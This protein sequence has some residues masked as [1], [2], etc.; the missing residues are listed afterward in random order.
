MSSL[1][2]A[3]LLQ[4]AAPVPAIDWLLLAMLLLGGLALFLFGLE[5]MSQS[6]RSAAGDRLKDVL[7]RLTEHRFSGLM[8]G[9]LVTALTQSSSV[10]TVML[11]GFVGAGLMKL[12]QTVAVIMGSNVGT[13]MTAQIIAFKVSHYAL[14]LVAIGYLSSLVIRRREPKLWFSALAGLGLIFYGMELMSTA[15]QPL[16]SHAPFIELMLSL[17]H[18][19]AG[20]A[21]G[22]L[23]TALVQSS[24][25][26]IALLIAL[27][28]QGLVSLPAAIAIAFGAEVGT[29][30]TA[31]LAGLG[32]S[33]EARR[34]AV[35][36]ILFNLLTVLV[37][38]PFIGALSRL[39]ML[40]SPLP[41]GPS[42][43]DALATVLPRQIANSLTFFNL[44]WALLLLP[45]TGVFA[46][47]ARR[48][49][50]EPAQAPDPDAPQFLSAQLLATPPAALE[51]VRRELSR[52]ADQVT[53]MLM[54]SRE[55][56]LHADNEGLAS[57][58]A[59]DRQ[60]DRLHDSI[61]EYLGRISL[62]TLSESDSHDFLALM[63]CGNALWHISNLVGDQLVHLGSERIRDGLLLDEPVRETIG[64][65]HGSVF[66]A[67]RLAQ[68]A[69]ADGDLQAAR[70]CRAM[71]HS[72]SAMMADARLGE[73][74]RLRGS[75]AEAMNVYGF[76]MGVL[77][78]YKRTY[79]YAARI[80]K[81]LLHVDGDGEDDD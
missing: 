50:R 80:A 42:P 56:V 38:L 77:E 61:V 66:E 76:E 45:A 74:A 14:L 17:E 23:F 25:A 21:V 18:P 63:R 37:S 75:S 16:R 47:L 12:S 4:G 26:T 78:C 34:V 48:I 57:L 9:F 67:C 53:A 64:H 19:L 24:S 29:C 69:L 1:S 70:D 35:V 5:H 22:F 36:H 59:R 33:T 79:Y 40:I 49:I 27:G 10:T 20:L 52:Q 2:P 60:A 72:I 3:M 30:I 73:A 13:T 62:S 65:V 8:T 46:A 81:T 15:M 32:N 6:L 28:S 41:V 43:L 7:K 58:R 31:L 11:V 71:K 39:A 55:L 51:M 54:D 44:F 68:R